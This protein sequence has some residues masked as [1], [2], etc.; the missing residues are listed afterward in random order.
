MVYSP[1]IVLIRDDKGEWRSPV[2]VDVLTSAPVNAGEVRLE[3]EMEERLGVERVEL[4]YWKKRVERKKQNEKATAERQRLREEKAEIQRQREENKKA[5][6]EI[7]KLEKEQTNMK[8]EMARLKNLV[9]EMGKRKETDIGKVK[10]SGSEREEPDAEVEDGKGEAEVE[11]SEQNQRNTIGSLDNGLGSNSDNQ[12][13]VAEDNTKSKGTMIEDDHPQ[14]PEVSQ[15]PASSS[16]VFYPRSPPTQASQPPVRDSNL[17]YALALKN[18]EIQIQQT[19]YDRIS[20]ILHL[21]QLHQTPH[22]I[23]GSFGAGTSKNRIDLIAVIFADLLIKAGG[24]FE[25]VF[26]TVVFAILG[27]ETLKVFSEVFKRADKRAQR[28]RTGKTRVFVDSYGG[29]SD[30]DMKEGVEEKTMR[31]MRWKARRSELER[32]SSL[33]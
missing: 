12:L 3:L 20:R 13:K 7:A 1:G 2:E 9:M 30:G 5:K 16:T 14:P 28:G 25:G 29:G 19:M 17:P 27:K 6:E 11:K 23:L 8:E 24:R 22:L 18:A 26:Q 32:K 21:F 15:E 33:N 31:M 4:E 10:E